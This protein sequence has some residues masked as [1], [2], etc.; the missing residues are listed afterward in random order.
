VIFCNEQCRV[1]ESRVVE[2]TEIDMKE[3]VRKHLI[4]ILIGLVFILIMTSAVLS[5]YNRQIM[6]HAVM[7]E[8]QSNFALKEVV[9]VYDNI[10]LMDI[11][12]RGYALIREPGYLF[13]SI[14]T[15]RAREKKTFQ[16]LDSVFALQGFKEEKYYPQVK[17]GLNDYTNMYAQ[18]VG[19]LQNHQDSAFVNLLR[20]DVGRYFWDVFNPFAEEFNAFEQKIK[21]DARAQYNQ[22]V[23]RNTLVQLL[24]VL[25]GL[26]TLV[27]VL[28]TLAKDERERRALIRDVDENN[29]QYLF[30]GGVHLKQEAK[31][32]LGNSIENLKKAAS[33][34]NEISVGNYEAKW[35]GLDEAHVE[36]NKN[37][38]A[39]RLV[40]MRD[41][42]KK[43]KEEDRKRIWA[44]EGLSEFSQIIRQFQNNLSELTFKSLTFIIKYTGS[45]QGSL[46]VLHKDTEEEEPYLKL[47]ACYA[48]ERKKHME[49]RIPIGEG[50]VGQTF[51]EGETMVLKTVP[52]GYISITSGLGDATPN[53]VIIVPLKYNDKVH[54]I[55]ELASFKD[56]EP[57]QITFLEK[58][59]EFIASAIASAQNN[60]RNQ[61]IMEQM[62]MQTEQLK[63]QEEELRQNLEE[64]EA[65]QEEMRRKSVGVET[66]MWQLKNVKTA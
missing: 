31:L 14:E 37:N 18:M 29:K 12:A 65:T 11:S 19:F 61:S 63:A 6:S 36:H 40:F 26:P 42:M 20:K 60:E 34:V 35:E 16:I 51:L 59:G 41:E 4:K 21:D 1:I 53:C 54:A 38:L 66:E 56:F 8:E 49:K 44:T 32:I 33:F 55:L 2:V 5:Y 43:V 47:S 30:D 7:L 64:L 62:R 10:K 15:A 39:G 28:F 52:E 48:F 57:Y 13:W 27:F 25:I 24:L 45:Q 22:A 46:F 9:N 23:V 3:F 58:A 50:L 17:K